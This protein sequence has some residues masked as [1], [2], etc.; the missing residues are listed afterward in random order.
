MFGKFDNG[1]DYDIGVSY[2][3]LSDITDFRGDDDAI[4]LY[5]KFSKTKKIS[6]NQTLTPYFKI[7][8]YLIPSGQADN[9]FSLFTGAFYNLKLDNK[10][11]VELEGTVGYDSGAYSFDNGT[12]GK[13]GAWLNYQVNDNL[14]AKFGIEL[15]S[16]FGDMNDSRKFQRVFSAGLTWKF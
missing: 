10:L 1:I 5:G 7:K 11:S 4:C 12:F 9:G 3:M 15:W 6:E 13:G 14:S 2:W 16:P 8:G